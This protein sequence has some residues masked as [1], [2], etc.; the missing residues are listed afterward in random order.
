MIQGPAIHMRGPGI[1]PELIR[2]RIARLSFSVPP[3]STADVTPAI[4]SC[5]AEI[6][7]TFSRS[8]FFSIHGSQR[9]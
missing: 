7:E 4:R 1:A 9:S 5:F 2:S 3:R 6:S 8:L